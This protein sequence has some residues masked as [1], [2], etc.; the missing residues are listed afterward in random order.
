MLMD[1]VIDSDSIIWLIKQVS[2]YLIIGFLIAMVAFGVE[3]SMHHFIK[4]NKEMGVQFLITTVVLI[5][6]YVVIYSIFYYAFGIDLVKG[7]LS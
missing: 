4:Q 6:G 2:K 3:R 1:I 7:L 5:V